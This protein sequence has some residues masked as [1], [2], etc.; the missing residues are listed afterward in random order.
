MTSTLPEHALDLSSF[1]RVR[2]KGDVMEF[3]FDQRR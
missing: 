3:F 1:G 2:S